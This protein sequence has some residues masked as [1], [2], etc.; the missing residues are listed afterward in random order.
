M[1]NLKPLLFGLIL[2]GLAALPGCF[3]GVYKID[4]QQGNVVTQDMVDQ[5]RPGMTQSQVQFVMGSPLITDSFHKNR[6]DYLYS[7]QPGGGQR[8]QERISL[9]FDANN[10]LAGLSGDFR[11]GVSREE[12]I[13][14][15]D[16]DN[17]Q[18]PAKTPA[19]PKKKKQQPTQPGS[20]E[21]R[22][23]RNVDEAQPVPVPEVEPLD[24]D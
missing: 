21:E 1:Q 11:P 5:L 19:A 14:G 2:P 8:Q 12:A 6:W 9:L 10:Q 23:Q 7:L 13:L 17:Q 24:H 4:V 22:L 15:Q 18:Q 16:R 3:P 20:L